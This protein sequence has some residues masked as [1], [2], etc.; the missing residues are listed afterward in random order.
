MLPKFRE[1][2]EHCGLSQSELAKKL[3]LKPQAVSKWENNI[4]AVPHLKPWQVEVLLDE[5]NISLEHLVDLSGHSRD[6][7]Y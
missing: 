6:S 4:D 3:G 5:L 7:N 2:R 1:L